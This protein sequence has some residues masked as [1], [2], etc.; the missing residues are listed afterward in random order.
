MLQVIGAE[1]GAG[2]LDGEIPPSPSASIALLFN[3][4]L[5]NLE[6]FVYFVGLHILKKKESHGATASA[7]G[8]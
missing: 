3:L 5:Q 7:V 1:L 4:L 2:C 8:R 6:L